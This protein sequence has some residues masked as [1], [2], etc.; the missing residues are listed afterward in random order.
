M[1]RTV[2]VNGTT[3]KLVVSGPPFGRRVA[4]KCGEIVLEDQTFV[5]DGTVL[6][7]RHIDAVASNA[8]KHQV[9]VTFTLSVS[10]KA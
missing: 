8:A 4:C 6:V 2:V 9:T 5:D 7:E 10:P 1:G 3:H